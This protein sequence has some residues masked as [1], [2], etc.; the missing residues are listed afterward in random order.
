MLELPTIPMRDGAM[1]VRALID[2]YM[3][4]YA[5]RD[6]TRLQRLS[7]WVSQLSETALQDLT[8]DHIHAA[9]Q[10]LTQKQAR[11]FAGNDADNN[12]IYRSGSVSQDNKPRYLRETWAG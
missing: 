4:H 5:G 8:D 10:A 6:T 9:I 2:L 1:T 12:P 11:Y 7:W 3:A